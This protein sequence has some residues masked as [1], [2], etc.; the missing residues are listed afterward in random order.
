MFRK[1]MVLAVF[2]ALAANYTAFSQSVAIETALSNAVKDIAASVPQGTKIAVLNM[3]SDYANLSDYII[4]ELIVNL[5]NTR[6]FQV[7]PRST[8]ELAL[9][10]REFAFQ[11]SGDV[12]DESQKRLGQFLGAGAIVSGS[13]T[14][15]SANSYRLVVN[16]I[17]LESFTYQTSY[18]ISIQNNKKMKELV[19]AA[20]GGAFNE[21]FDYTTGQRIGMGALNIFGGAGSLMNG[22]KIGG[23]TTGLEAAGLLAIL[24]GQFFFNDG[25]QRNLLVGGGSVLIGAGVVFG[26]VVPFFHHK[27]GAQISQNNVPFNLELVSSNNQEVNGFRIS[28]NMRF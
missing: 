13:I 24:G 4:D 23:L 16:A 2:L 15:D 28:Y 12:S 11:M 26:F 27:P 6:A 18:R 7:V 14:R 25:E 3:S 19:T 20:G 5:V 10:R 17:D 21:D 9:A 1:T 8:V 22:H